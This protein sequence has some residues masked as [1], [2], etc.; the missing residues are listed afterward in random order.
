MPYVFDEIYNQFYSFLERNF[1]FMTNADLGFLSG[2]AGALKVAAIIISM[3]FLVGVV[4]NIW[5]FVDYRRKHISEIVKF[6]MEPV[7]GDRQSRWSAVKVALESENAADWKMAIIEADN[8]I[9]DILQKANYKG[10]NLGERLLKIKSHTFKNLANLFRAHILRNKI[11]RK[12]NGVNLTK[13]KTA[14]ILN[15]YEEALKEMGYL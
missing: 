15:L 14:E 6:I 11:S 3:L 7:L 5:R 9:D 4:Y 12:G 10:N 8:I 1:N 13:E 2:V